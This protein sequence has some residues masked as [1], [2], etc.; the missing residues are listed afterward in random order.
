[1]KKLVGP[2]SLLSAEKRTE[3]SIVYGLT[4]SQMHNK[5]ILNSYPRE[6]M[7]AP[8]LFHL[9]FISHLIQMCRFACCPWDGYTD[10]IVC[11]IHG[12]VPGGT[13]LIV[14]LR[15]CQRGLQNCT[16][17]IAILLRFW[18]KIVPYMLAPPRYLI[19]RDY[20]PPPPGGE[21]H[22]ASHFWSP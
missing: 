1:M 2:I 21:V 8:I 5:H 20:P 17:S 22:L 16:L 12:E 7:W 6:G 18:C 4:I 14:V 13:C 11:N 9:H 3:R 19:F 15:V 10:Q